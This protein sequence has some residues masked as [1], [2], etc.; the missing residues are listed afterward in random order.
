MIGLEKVY[1]THRGLMN[2]F[3]QREV[4]NLADYVK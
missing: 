3:F 2:S 4:E 1:F